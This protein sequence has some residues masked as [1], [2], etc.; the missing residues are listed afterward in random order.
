MPDRTTVVALQRE[1]F[2]GIKAGSA[3]F[4]WLTATGMS[5]LLIALLAAAGVVFGV[6]TNSTVSVDQAV[7]ESQQAT[8]TAQTVGLVGAITLLVVLL[9]A[10]YW[11]RVCGRADGP[12]QR[13]QAGFR[14]G[15]G[16]C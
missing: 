7:Q 3:F 10:Y 13:R 16:V 6:A 1:R 15:C 4:G 5:V 14:G 2:G 11:R 8:G 9:V 12:V